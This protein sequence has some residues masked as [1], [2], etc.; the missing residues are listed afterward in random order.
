MVTVST[1]GS[2]LCDDEEGERPPSSGPE[3]ETKSNHLQFKP[4][5]IEVAVVKLTIS[6]LQ[7]WTTPFYFFCTRPNVLKTINLFK[8]NR[9]YNQTTTKKNKHVVTHSGFKWNGEMFG[10]KMS[11]VQ[12]CL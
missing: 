4:W 10:G 1:S 3:K 6:E 12:I 11:A 8:L 7:F 5:P 9:C 2:S